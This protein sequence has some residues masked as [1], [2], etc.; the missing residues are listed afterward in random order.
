MGYQ[1]IENLYKAR[2]ILLFRE[3]YALEKVHGTSAHIAWKEGQTTLFA[4][5][6]KHEEF[7][8]V[9]EETSALERLAERSGEPLTIYGEAYGGKL[10]GMS[11]TYGPT[12]RFI[13]FEVRIGQRWLSVPQAEEVAVGHGFEFVP[14]VKTTTDVAEL[15]MLRDAPSVV[16]YRNGCG[17]RH[18]EGVVLRPLIEVTKNNG[19][20]IIA[21]HKGEAFSERVR[22]PN[23]SAEKLEVLASAKAIADEWVTEMRLAHVLDKLPE[24]TGIE[25]T[26]IVIRAMIEDVEREAAGEIV[27]SAD[28]RRAIGQAAALIYERRVTEVPHAR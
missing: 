10:Q 6:A 20:R 17:E 9:I 7:R 8:K 23:V 3:C 25:H 14:Y 27:V 5:G 13:A 1:H 16:A 19:D 26:P 2:D 24:A 28:A 15:D 11:E 18:R 21:K 4:G 22:I 12:L